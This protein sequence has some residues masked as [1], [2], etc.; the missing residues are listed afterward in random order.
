M[1]RRDDIGERQRGDRAVRYV[2][3]AR[4]IG[5]VVVD[6]RAAQPANAAVTL[7]G[8]L[9]VPNLIALLR[10]RDEM[11]AAVLD[12]LDR[13]AQLPCRESD[14]HL[15]RVEHELWAEA[16][17]D[18]GR[19]DPQPVLVEP[20]HVAKIAARGMRRLRRR[21]NRQLLVE[22]VVARHDTAT[23]HGMG[24]A[25]M[26]RQRFGEDV[27]CAGE[28]AFDV[29]VREIELRHEIVF[30]ARMRDGRARHQRRA[31][32]VH[33]RQIPILDGDR[34]DGILGEIAI[35]G[36]HGDDRLADVHDLGSRQHRAMQFEPVARRGQRD[37]QQWIG[38]PPVE[39]G[40]RPDSADAWH[41][42]RRVAADRADHRVGVRTAHEGDMERAG[43][44]DVVDEPPLAL[45]ERQV[46]Q[47]L[48]AVAKDVGHAASTPI[49]L[50]RPLNGGPMC[51]E[52]VPL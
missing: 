41:R 46:L 4:R 9:H 3:A 7:D 32:I 50:R 19:H 20:E 14:D 13:A 30:G 24:D 37:A 39:I 25:A 49:R 44:V 26:L 5:A 43:Q 48:D 36:D 33:R 6:Q 18:V 12:P 10:R 2:D 52:I 8:N 1:Q 23:F 38:Q 29:P 28:G 16:A 11:L 34:V 47:A 15:L 40:R 21:P 22:T 51:H 45:Q 42:A 17:A 27:R 35:V 31:A